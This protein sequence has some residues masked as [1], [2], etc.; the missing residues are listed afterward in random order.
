MDDYLD[1]LSSII[2]HRR[3][4]DID[5]DKWIWMDLALDF[6]VNHAEG[7][8]AEEIQ[9]MSLAIKMAELIDDRK[10]WLLDEVDQE[11]RA[12]AA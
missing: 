11:V 12:I 3:I 10:A 1:F 4:R 9:R 7:F 6:L 8:T 5:K 2:F